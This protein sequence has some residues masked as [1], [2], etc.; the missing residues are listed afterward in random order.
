M[1]CI[2][3][4]TKVWVL[5]SF[6]FSEGNSTYINK[7]M[8]LGIFFGPHFRYQYPSITHQ[9]DWPEAMMSS[10]TSAV[11]ISWR[12]ARCFLSN[13]GVPGAGRQSSH[14]ADDMKKHGDHQKGG[15]HKGSS[16]QQ[17]QLHLDKGSQKRFSEMEIYFNHFN[18]W[19]IRKSQQ[20]PTVVV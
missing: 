8:V 1:F 12:L 16:S 5:A 19:K 14:L 3:P 9:L 7:M 15:E 6:N 4:D 2:I 10:M 13:F 18:T 17:W 20:I 11:C